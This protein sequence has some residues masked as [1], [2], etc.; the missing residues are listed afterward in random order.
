M[1]GGRGRHSTEAVIQTTFRLT[2][3][4]SSYCSTLQQIHIINR[5][6]SPRWIYSRYVCGKQIKHWEWKNYANT[7]A[8]AVI[9]IFI[10]HKNYSESHCMV[11][12]VK[13]GCNVW[14]HELWMN[15]SVRTPYPHGYPILLSPFFYVFDREKEMFNN[16]KMFGFL[17][18]HVDCIK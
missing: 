12:M 5:K 17:F 2:L 13:D 6:Y 4:S 11:W 7:F 8:T 18:Q 14:I 15:C 1:V 3:N 9:W 16:K 10:F